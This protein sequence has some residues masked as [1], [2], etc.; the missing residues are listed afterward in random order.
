MS[1]DEFTTKLIFLG[2]D[3][4]NK[5][6]YA[7]SKNEDNSLVIIGENQVL[8]NSAIAPISCNKAFLAVL[9][10]ENDK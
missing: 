1:N 4:K 10:K 5:F 7:G 9:Q 6:G 3:I 2:W 8:I